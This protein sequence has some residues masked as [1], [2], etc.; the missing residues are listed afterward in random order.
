MITFKKLNESLSNPYDYE[1]KNITFNWMGQFETDNGSI[2]YFHA[3]KLK[4]TQS[5]Y[6]FNFVK[7]KSS[8][9]LGM[10]KFDISDEKTGTGDQF[11]VFAT[12]KKMFLEFVSV[13][14]PKII[15]LYMKTYKSCT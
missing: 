12:I 3:Y 14:R 7:D 8:S 11:R 9:F 4:V 6:I 13:S 2:Y 1:W 10:K 15:M 5:S